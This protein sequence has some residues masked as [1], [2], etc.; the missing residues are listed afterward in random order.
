MG[1]III[2]FGVFLSLELISIIAEQEG[3]SRVQSTVQGFVGTMDE[4]IKVNVSS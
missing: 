2:N 1:I 3:P 4:C